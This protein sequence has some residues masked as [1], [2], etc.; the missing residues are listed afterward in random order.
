[1]GFAFYFPEMFLNHVEGTGLKVPEDA[2]EFNK[3]EFPHWE[4]FLLLH[5]GRNIPNMNDI[6][7]NAEIIAKIPDDQI[8]KITVNQLQAL[9]V[10]LSEGS[11]LY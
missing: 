1:M 8:R 2:S 5:L 9:G 6:H 10:D 4:V 7:Y 11:T 3:D